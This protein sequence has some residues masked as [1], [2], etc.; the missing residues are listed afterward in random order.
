MSRSAREY[1]RD[2][3]RFSPQIITPRPIA[4]SSLAT[5]IRRY[6]ASAGNQQ[7]RSAGQMLQL[8][9]DGLLA[10]AAN[11]SVCCQVPWTG[12]ITQN[13]CCETTADGSA[14]GLTGYFWQ[15]APL[16]PLGIPGPVVYEGPKC[17][18]M[19]DV[20]PPPTDVLAQY[21][22]S[23]GQGAVIESF[24]VEFT[25]PPASSKVTAYQL[26]STDGTINIMSTTA[27]ISIPSGSFVY[28][29]TY[30]FIVFAFNAEGPSV[31][32]AL[33]NNI[34]P[35]RFPDPPSAVSATPGDTSVTIRFTPPV[36]TG[37]SPITEY[38]VYTS[39]DIP[40]TTG[41]A[42]GSP[43]VVT[44]LTNGTPYTFRVTATN[45]VG[46]SFYSDAVTATPNPV[47]TPDAPVINYTLT[48]DGAGWIYF[49]EGNVHGATLTKYQYDIGDGYVD[50]S[51]PL[52]SPFQITSLTNGTTYTVIMRAVTADTNSADSASATL[53]P[54]SA[55]APTVTWEMDP[56]NNAC[57]SGSGTNVYFVGTGAPGVGT[58]RGSLGTT[59]ATPGGR[60]F[61]F[62]GTQYISFLKFNLIPSGHTSITVSAWI[63]PSDKFSIN[64]LLAN[65]PA[66]ANTP[67]FKMAWNS[68]QSRNRNY[69]FEHGSGTTNPASGWSVPSSS[70]NAIVNGVWQFITYAFNNSAQRIIFYHN[71]LPIIMGSIHTSPNVDMN[72]TFNIG[73]YINGGYS[74]NMLLAD[75]RMFT[76][77]LNAAQVMQDYLATKARYGL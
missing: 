37:G 1:L 31:E 44:G 47:I 61:N 72:R 9:T 59:I 18:V 57:Y 49:T 67:G 20:P 8:S 5:Q 53:T 46:S 25:P 19:T 4:D 58:I 17:C 55:A 45:N 15:G 33:S 2:K 21:S 16:R 11:K 3:Q 30:Q 48:D 52:Q 75:L 13:A 51:L 74:P 71:G 32:S 36:V 69:I 50:L 27:P 42:D 54:N 70:S 77:E 26:I 12:A 6:K 22:C 60:V 23:Q 43:I 41:T 38:T 73:A 63:K 76:S 24:T 56:S 65:G 35:L 62:T 14:A 39:N 40:P 64:T 7:Q 10:A 68:W 34:T 66:N 29:T 28:G